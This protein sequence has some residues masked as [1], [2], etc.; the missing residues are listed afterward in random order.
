MNDVLKLRGIAGILC[1]V[2]NRF[3]WILGYVKSGA[4][5]IM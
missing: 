5:N 3:F 2:Q 4:E 1:Y